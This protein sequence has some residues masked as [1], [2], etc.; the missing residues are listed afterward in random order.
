[1]AKMADKQLLFIGLG[2]VWVRFADLRLIG[3]GGMGAGAAGA[4]EMIPAKRTQKWSN[5]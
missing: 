3:G 5:T 1:M 2:W 4:V